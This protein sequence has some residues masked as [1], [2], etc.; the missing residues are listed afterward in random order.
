MAEAS[1]GPRQFAR[2][3]GRYLLSVSD[4]IVGRLVGYAL[5]TDDTAT[6]RVVFHALADSL[7]PHADTPIDVPDFTS[8]SGLALFRAE[9]VTP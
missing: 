8:P 3:R 4:L 5:I 2:A 7:Y 9:G 1:D 6:R